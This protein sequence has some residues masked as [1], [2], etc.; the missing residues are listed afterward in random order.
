MYYTTSEPRSLRGYKSKKDLSPDRKINT[1]I[2]SEGSSYHLK[3][4]FASKSKQT[5]GLRKASNTSS[6]SKITS[7]SNVNHPNKS[8]VKLKSEK[9][10]FAVSSDPISMSIAERKSSGS[11]LSVVSG[12]KFRQVV[13]DDFKYSQKEGEFEPVFK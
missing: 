2:T 1:N 8:D 5:F 11:Y 6:S 10:P 7:S 9:G 13:E 12:S 3:G 4:T